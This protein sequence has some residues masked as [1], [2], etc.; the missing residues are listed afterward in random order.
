MHSTPL[1]IHPSLLH[2]LTGEPLRAVG[3]RQNGRPIWPVIGASQ[4]F[5]EQPAVPP[6]AP[7]PPAAPAAPAA[8]APVV[9]PAVPPVAPTPPAETGFPANTPLEQMTIEQQAAYW[10]HY[11]RQHEATAKSRGDYDAIKAKADEYDRFRAANATEHEKAVKAAA[12]AARA[13]ERLASIPRIVSAEFR[14]ASVGRISPEAL[15]ALLEPLDMSK[16]VDAKGDVD[17]AKVT[18][19]I[20]GIAPK[21][22]TPPPAFPDL[23][24]G[25]RPGGAG[26][27]VAAGKALFAAQQKPAPTN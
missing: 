1:P 24:Q 4:A 25:V 7:A 14:A 16:F 27:S 5:P 18:A 10:K 26:P 2:P 13:E 6:V 20:D 21:T 17:T 12:D 9:P 22:G 11:S 8:P 3:L 23:G 15:T 19:F